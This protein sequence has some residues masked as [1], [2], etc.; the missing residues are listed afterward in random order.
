MKL[1]S[2]YEQHGE[3]HV[4]QGKLSCKCFQQIEQRNGMYNDLT[5]EVLLKSSMGGTRLSLSQYK[6]QR[7]DL[8]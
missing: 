7:T 5:Q 8:G 3:H 6:K 4:A 1:I 2:Y